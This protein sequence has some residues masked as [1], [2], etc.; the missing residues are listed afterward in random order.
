MIQREETKQFQAGAIRR[1]TLAWAANCVV[2]PKKD[3][4]ARVCQDYQGLTTVL[5]SD[6]GGLGDIQ[7]VFDDM[8]G[9]GCF[10]SIDMASGFTQ[11]EIVEEDKH[12][13][14]FRDAHGALQEFNRC[15]FSL[16]TLPAGFAASVGGALGALKGK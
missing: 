16:K 15:G 8:K 13:T 9:A 6:S 5:K 10:T 1:S 11:L 14:A 2:L 7:S 12:K 3:G 4:T